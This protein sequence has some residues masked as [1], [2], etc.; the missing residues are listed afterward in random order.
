MNIASRI[1]PRAAMAAFVTNMIMSATGWWVH[2]IEGAGHPP[3]I[4]RVSLTAW[5]LINGVLGLCILFD[6][7]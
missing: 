4:A 1:G 5:F 7:D 3:I 2:V 6:R